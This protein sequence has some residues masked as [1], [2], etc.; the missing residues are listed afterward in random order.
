[1]KYFI[2]FSAIVLI[3]PPAYSLDEWDLLALS[4]DGE[5]NYKYS[6]CYPKSY[7]LENIAPLDGEIK[8]DARDKPKL[9]V[10]ISLV[11]EINNIQYFDI[12]QQYQ[13]Q[14]QIKV[15]AFSNIKKELCPFYAW[16]PTEGFVENLNSEIVPVREH[17]VIGHYLKVYRGNYFEY[18]AVNDDGP[19]LLNFNTLALNYVKEN[20]PNYT[21]DNTDFNIKE[22]TYSFKLSK[23][24]DASCCPT[25]SFIKLHYSLNK[26]QIEIVKVEKISSQPVTRKLGIPP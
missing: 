13:G 14:K 6:T 1:M 24:S 19:F 26:E 9:N 20:H 23:N 22:L 12:I 21:L 11:G 4:G 18:F 17:L 2:I 3:T 5:S 16:Q 15:I 8:W 7:F 10:D 25:G